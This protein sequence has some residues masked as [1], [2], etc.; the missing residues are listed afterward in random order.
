M[1]NG[2]LFNIFKLKNNF[3]FK[4]FTT[5]SIKLSKNCHYLFAFSQKYDILLLNMQPIAKQKEC[6]GGQ[7]IR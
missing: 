3:S 5:F 6:L 1:E 2:W 7:L 4:I